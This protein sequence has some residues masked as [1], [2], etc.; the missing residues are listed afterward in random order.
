[1][2]VLQ[3]QLHE[4]RG[5]EATDLSVCVY[6]GRGVAKS[7]DISGKQKVANKNMSGGRRARRERAVGRCSKQQVGHKII[8]LLRKIHTQALLL[9]LRP[10]GLT[11][12]S[13]ASH[14]GWLK[15]L[16]PWTRKR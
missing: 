14:P 8:Y 2:D 15:A 4:G 3:S 13:K 16:Q 9:A 6:G 1:M 12:L 10:K 7:N 11:S 5:T